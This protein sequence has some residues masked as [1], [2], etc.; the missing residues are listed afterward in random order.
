MERQK[1][2]RPFSARDKWGYAFGDLGC[3]LSFSLVSTYM[4]LFYTQY[5]GLETQ[6]WEWII[7]VSKAW[8]AI[9]DILIGNMVDRRRI[10]KK[11]KFTPWILIGAVGLVFLTVMIFFAPAQSFSYNP[12][13]R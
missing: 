3:G 1:Q 2:L 11:S 13:P 8:D 6:D 7:V 10:S 5:I 12:R 4:L 9:N